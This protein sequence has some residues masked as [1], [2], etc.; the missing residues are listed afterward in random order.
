MQARILLLFF[1]IIALPIWV[2][3]I[4][5]FNRRMTRP[6]RI[7]YLVLFITIAVGAYFTTYRYDYY[8]NQNTHFYGWPMPTVIYQRQDPSSRWLDFVGLPTVFAYPINICLLLF[9]PSL[10]FLVIRLLRNRRKL[11]HDAKPVTAP[12]ESQTDDGEKP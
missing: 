9:V 4:V 2:G 3:I 10:I 1:V 11:A 12:S 8:M 6:F 7:V 5:V